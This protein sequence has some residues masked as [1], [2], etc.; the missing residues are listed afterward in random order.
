LQAKNNVGGRARRAQEITG[1]DNGGDAAR[2]W[3]IASF[4]PI[5]KRFEED[6]ERL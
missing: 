4:G 6:Q 3:D 5:H 1:T 2:M